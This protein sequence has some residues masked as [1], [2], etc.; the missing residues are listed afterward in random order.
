MS[1]CE[2]PGTTEYLDM[3]LNANYDPLTDPHRV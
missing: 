3:L 1:R 2:G